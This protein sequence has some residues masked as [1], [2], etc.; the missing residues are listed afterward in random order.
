M[1]KDCTYTRLSGRPSARYM[2]KDA[3]N[4]QWWETLGPPSNQP[5]SIQEDPVKPDQSRDDDS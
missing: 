1:Y 3:K 2:K 4:M 5:Y